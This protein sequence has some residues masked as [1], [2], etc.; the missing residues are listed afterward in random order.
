MKTIEHEQTLQHH[1]VTKDFLI[2]DIVI[3][4]SLDT[5]VLKKSFFFLKE[6]TNKNNKKARKWPEVLSLN[7][8]FLSSSQIFVNG[9]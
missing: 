3:D 9:E 4:A 8:A 1:M 5:S 7:A 6:N 2:I